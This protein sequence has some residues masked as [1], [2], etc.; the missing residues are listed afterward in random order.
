M[1][2]VDAPVFFVIQGLT[3]VMLLIWALRL[4]ISPKPRWLWLPM[5]WVVL[6]FTAWPLDVIYRGH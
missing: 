5:N 4:W 2:A 3:V 1:G 6:A